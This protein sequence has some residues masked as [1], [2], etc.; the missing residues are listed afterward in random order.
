MKNVNTEI[1]DIIYSNKKTPGYDRY[2]KYGK[3]I[4]R[5]ITPLKYLSEEESTYYPI[6][7]FLMDKTKLEILEVGCGYG[8]LTYSLHSLG[9][10]IVGIDISKKAIDFASSHFG[11]YYE[12]SN[13]KNYKPKK[14]FDLII[15]TELIEHLSNP[16]EFISLCV[17]LLNSDGKIILTTPNYYNKISVWRTDSPP[18]HTV[19][20]SKDSFKY[21]AKKKLKCA[22]VDFTNYLGKNENKLL[23]F[24]C[25]K[26]ISNSLPLPVLNKKGDAYQKR[27]D[28]SNSLVRM[29]VRNV[30]RKIIFSYPVRYI[31]SNITNLF[32][33][34][35]NTLGVIL[36]KKK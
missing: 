1:Y 7:K 19:W 31:C 12:V 16:V 35:H 6:Y 27:V 10:N 21:I 34:E 23:E 13:I 20:L 14:Q 8:Y 18:V 28:I 30:F 29:F 32:T 15:A 5:Q 4:K 11:N 36:W 22:F 2:L 17:N 24:L 25:M 26:F 33:K 9:H 3:E